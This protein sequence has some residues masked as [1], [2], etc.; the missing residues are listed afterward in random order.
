M[1]GAPKKK[2]SSSSLPLPWLEMG[3]TQ[4]PSI[5]GQSST[6]IAFHVSAVHDVC[7]TR[8]LRRP[9]LCWGATG[10]WEVRVPCREHTQP[11]LA[12][13][14]PQRASWCWC[15]W[16]T[17]AMRGV[18][19]GEGDN[20]VGGFWNS[21]RNV[22]SH[23]RLWVPVCRIER[24]DRR[25]TGNILPTQPSSTQSLW[26]CW[27]RCFIQYW[28]RDVMLC[29]RGPSKRQ[30]GNSLYS[31]TSFKGFLTLTQSVYTSPHSCYSVLFNFVWL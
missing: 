30:V 2:S 29:L 10:P 8:F 12:L 1:S 6:T 18:R 28:L 5:S 9:G 7:P 20:W 26:D 23:G 3:L 31:G 15:S 27:E 24:K 13:L 22:F 14:T 25:R 19:T 11:L 16:G 17:K 21:L 4:F